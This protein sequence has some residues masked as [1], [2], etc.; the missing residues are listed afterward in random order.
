M[1][2][3]QPVVMVEKALDQQKTALGVFLDIAGAFNNTSYD[4][5]C[6]VLF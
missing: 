2:S 1:A 4:S 6:A 3:H 5:T